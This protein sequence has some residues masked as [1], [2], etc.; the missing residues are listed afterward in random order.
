MASTRKIIADFVGV[1]LIGGVAGGL[2]TWSVLTWSADNQLPAVMSRWNNPDIL[3][4]RIDAKYAKDYQLTPD[5]VQKIQPVV[6]QM[7]QDIYK[8]RHQFGA[9]IITTLDSYHAQIAAQLTPEHRAAYEAKMT[10]LH[11]Q[12]SVLLLTD[13]SSPTPGQK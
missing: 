8:V 5:E 13:Q 3:E 10:K 2:V 7:A 11:K 12:L 9:D 6:K 1:F 4:A